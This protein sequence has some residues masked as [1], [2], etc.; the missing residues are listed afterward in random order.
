MPKNVSAELE[1]LNKIKWYALIQLLLLLLVFVISA[2]ASFFAA[3]G[4]ATVAVMVIT[5]AGILVVAVISIWLIMGA[6]RLLSSKEKGLR[7]ARIA[8][9][10]GGILLVIGLLGVIAAALSP[11]FLLSIVSVSGGQS[12]GVNAPSASMLCSGSSTLPN[13]PN[14]AVISTMCNTFNT[15]KNVIFILGLIFLVVGGL[16][17]AIATLWGLWKVG[18]AYNNTSIKIGAVTTTIINIPLVGQVLLYLGVN[19]AIKKLKKG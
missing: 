10:L 16:V 7:K 2:S 15:I 18:S 17:Y 4:T 19:D 13:T 3:N 11:F 14:D 5:Y 9:I 6:F 8:V 1:G 12:A